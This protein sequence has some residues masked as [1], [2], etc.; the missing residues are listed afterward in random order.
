MKKLASTF[1]ITLIILIMFFACNHLIENK[2]PA[3]TGTLAEVLVI[4]PQKEWKGQVGFVVKDMLQQDIV[5]VNASEPLFIPRYIEPQ[6]FDKIYLTFRKIL[7]VNV[8]DTVKKNRILYFQDVYAHPQMFIDVYA[9]NDSLAIQLLQQKAN[10]IIQSFR[11]TEILRLQ[12]VFKQY[13]NQR[14]KKQ[15]SEQFGFYLTM[16]ESYYVAKT[17]KDFAWYRFEP[18]DYS[19]GILVYT[20]EFKDSSQLLP[21]SIL[22]YRNQITKAYIPG[23]LEGSYMSTEEQFPPEVD[24]VPFYNTRA[25]EIRHLWK[26]INDYMGGP[27]LSYTFHDVVNNRIITL[28]GYAFYPNHDKRELMF[29]IEAVLRSYT[30]VQTKK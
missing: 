28:E 22:A 20:R 2:L 5:G 24:T 1:V 13:A 14:I 11:E 9:Q 30:P 12:E 4:M 25:I 18:K 27:F 26:T 7:R 16:Q 17:A 15:I 23:Q 29:H 10:H 19:I 3:G 21:E 6:Q 8:A